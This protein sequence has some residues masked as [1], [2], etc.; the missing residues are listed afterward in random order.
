[1]GTT[2]TA[3]LFADDHVGLV[4]VGDSRAYLLRDESLHQITK[5]ETF[6][7][8]LVDAGRLAP[9]SVATHPQRSIVLRALDGRTLSPVL[10]RLD[11]LPGDRYLVCS[12]G[13]S[14]VLSTE[15]LRSALLADDPQESAFPLVLSAMRAGSTDNVSCVA[16][17]A[18]D[19]DF[20]YNIP[21]RLGAASIDPAS[22]A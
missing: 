22:S 15:R 6:V 10:G 5:D 1:M 11:V 16:A 3:L 2:V 18:A 8:S 21:L 13:V 4:H 17:F 20:G 19:R 14:D 7:Q 12:D 9:Q